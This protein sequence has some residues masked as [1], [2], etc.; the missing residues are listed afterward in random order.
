VQPGIWGEHA[1]KAAQMQAR[2]RHQRG[3]VSGVGACKLERY[4][5]A[6]H[7]LLRG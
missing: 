2:T 1:L 5:A 4:G 3:Q 7:D 6:L